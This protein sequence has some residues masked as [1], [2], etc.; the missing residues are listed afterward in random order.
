MVFTGSTSSPTTGASSSPIAS[1]ESG[2]PVTLTAFLFNMVKRQAL[3][4]TFKKLSEQNSNITVDLLVNDQ[5]Y[6]TVLKTKIASNDIPDIVMGEYGDLLELGQAGH[7]LN[8]AGDSYIQNYSEQ[9]RS[10]MSTPD[11]KIYGIPLDISGMGIY[12]NKDLFEK[13]GIEAFPKTQTELQ[14]IN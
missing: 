8:L 6:Y 7:I 13:S 4:E 12:Y 11:G 3:E 2:K 10:W 9:I 14:S 5:D 1:I